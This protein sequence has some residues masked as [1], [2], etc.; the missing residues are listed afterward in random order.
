MTYLPDTT[1]G[2]VIRDDL[3]RERDEKNGWDDGLKGEHPIQPRNRHYMRAWREGDAE[4]RRQE[5]G[6]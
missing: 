3:D 1:M 2:K 5:G 4:R 6:R